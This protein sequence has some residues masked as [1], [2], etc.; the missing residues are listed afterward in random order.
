MLRTSCIFLRGYDEP[1]A[2][3]LEPASVWGD[4]AY[5]PAKSNCQS[6]VRSL[7]EP[8]SFVFIRGQVESCLAEF[9][10][11]LACLSRGNG[12]SFC[13]KVNTFPFG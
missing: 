13:R 12:D 8:Q 2:L 9:Q 10:A 6:T 4:K 11:P 7:S 1:S 5:S 3:V